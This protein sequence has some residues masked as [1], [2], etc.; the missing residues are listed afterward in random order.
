M[1]SFEP[2]MSI[3]RLAPWENPIHDRPKLPLFEESG[4]R[5][6]TFAVGTHENPVQ[7]E[8]AVDGRVQ[9]ASECHRCGNSSTWP[10]ER[11]SASDRIAAHQVEKRINPGRESSSKLFHDSPVGIAN[12]RPCAKVEECGPVSFGGD[13]DDRGAAPLGELHGK[14]AYSARSPDNDNRL[15]AAGV[16]SLYCFPG[17]AR[18]KRHCGCV[19]SSDVAGNRNRM[20]GGHG[21]ELSVRTF[22]TPEEV[23]HQEDPLADP[24]VLNALTELDNDTRRIGARDKWSL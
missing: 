24:A 8:I 12:A 2:T 1:T 4:D 22:S 17:S 23:R 14:G 9:I 20:R 11:D 18:G 3:G 6:K 10:H 13:R 15:F 7:R 5:M 16:E 21:D 19:L